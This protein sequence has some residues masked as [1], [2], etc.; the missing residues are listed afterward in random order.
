MGRTLMGETAIGEAVQFAVQQIASG[1]F[2]GSRRLIDVSGDGRSNVGVDPDGLRDDAVAAGITIN[3]L[4]I[5]NDDITLDL[6]YADHVI[7]GHDDF[8]MT[9]RDFDDFA[10]AIR[11]KL[12]QEIRGAPL[13]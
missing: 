11:F 13:G 4:A 3:G 10:R 8:V 2:R 5:L 12:L 6:D 7:G 9:T 1:P